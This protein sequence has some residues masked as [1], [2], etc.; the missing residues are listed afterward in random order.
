MSLGI[1]RRSIEVMSNYAKERQAFGKS[2]GEYGQIQKRGDER[3]KQW[4]ILYY[5]YRNYTRVEQ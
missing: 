1:A 5:I 3:T 4:I 2:I